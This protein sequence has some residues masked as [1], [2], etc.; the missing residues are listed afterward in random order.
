M[1]NV[2][3]LS[4]ES[5]LRTVAILGVGAVAA[6]ITIFACTKI[7]QEP[8]QSVHGVDDYRRLLLQSPS[9]LRAVFA[10]DN[11]FIVFYSSVFVLL[12]IVCLREGAHRLV[13]A[14]AL[15][16]LLL[17]G[18][19]DMIENFHLMSLLA[20]AVQ[21]I[22]FSDGDIRFQSL[23][24]LLKFH[25]SYLGLFLLGFVIP[26]TTRS[27]R[28]LSWINWSVQLPVGIL[29]YATPQRIVHAL[30][31]L[32]FSFFVVGLLLVAKLAHERMRRANT[33]PLHAGRVV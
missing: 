23:E 14:V 24:T 8:L 5:A 19:L 9:V 13:L 33:L 31:L 6:M 4:V 26:R 1:K 3:P 25:M 28:V 11:A 32:R 27:G 21:G 20:S 16:A 10:F 7:G 15:G 12:A 29:I 22:P 2:N 18:L 30:V 17:T